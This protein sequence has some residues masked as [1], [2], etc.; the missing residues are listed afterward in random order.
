MLKSGKSQTASYIFLQPTKLGSPSS[1]RGAFATAVACLSE[2]GL[3]P[4]FCLGPRQEGHGTDT[5]VSTSPRGA[6]LML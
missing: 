5:G 3:P 4:F 1:S 2:R 6:K